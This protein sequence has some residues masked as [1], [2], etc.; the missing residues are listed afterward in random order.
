M[1]GLRTEDRDGTRLVTLDRPPLNA[2]D[3]DLLEAL[4]AAIADA[5]PNQPT[6]LAGT[7]KAFSAGVDTK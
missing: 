5:E 4:I 3:L 7:G 2:L 6:V 1:T